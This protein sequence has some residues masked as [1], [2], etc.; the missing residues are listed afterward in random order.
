MMKDKLITIAIEFAKVLVPAMLVL[1]QPIV[2]WMINRAG[3]GKRHRL[4]E[5]R[6]KEFELLEKAIALQKTAKESEGPVSE[7][8]KIKTSIVI[9]DVMDNFELARKSEEAKILGYTNL[10]WLKKLLLLF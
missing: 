9:D 7:M 3:I 6:I 5:L 2:T 4:V 10:N 8:A 1:L